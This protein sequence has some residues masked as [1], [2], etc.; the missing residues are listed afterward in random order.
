MMTVVCSK[1]HLVVTS[2]DL[3]TCPACDRQ[4]LRKLANRAAF[5]ADKARRAEY[6]GRTGK[7]YRCPLCG[8]RIDDG[9]PC[10]CGAR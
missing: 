10:G 7:P 2:V 5:A 6:E 3:D 4:A 9:K 1:G 8:Q